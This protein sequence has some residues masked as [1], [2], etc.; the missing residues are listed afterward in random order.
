MSTVRPIEIIKLNES[1][2]MYE[3]HT[4]QLEQVLNR[5]DVGDSNL[6]VVSICGAFRKGKSLIMSFFLDFIKE[7]VSYKCFP[8]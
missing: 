2:R 7:T 3:L 8:H 5:A 1:T 4:D 6:A